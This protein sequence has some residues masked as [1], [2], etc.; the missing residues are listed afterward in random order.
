MTQD[1]MKLV[2]IYYHFEFAEAIERILDRQGIENYLRHSRVA[3][4]DREGK[5]F[6]T[7][8]Y[9][10]SA[11]MAQAQVPAEGVAPLLEALRDFQQAEAS[12]QHLSAVVLPVEELLA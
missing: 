5:H 6:G 11:S 1:T 9:P 8:I 3:G 2:Q 10:G 12:H 4:R 7:K